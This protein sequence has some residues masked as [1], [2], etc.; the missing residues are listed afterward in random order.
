MIMLR[1]YKQYAVVVTRE[2]RDDINNEYGE[3]IGEGPSRTVYVNATVVAKTAD[4][5]VAWTLKRYPHS[6]FDSVSRGITL[7]AFIVEYT[8]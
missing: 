2:H 4:A 7:D 5:A 8:S 1:D 3:K 6:L